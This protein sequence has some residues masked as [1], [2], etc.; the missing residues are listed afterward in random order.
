MPP[1]WAEIPLCLKDKNTY[2]TCSLLNLLEYVKVYFHAHVLR[3]QHVIGHRKSL[4]VKSRQKN[5]SIEIAFSNIHDCLDSGA[6][7]KCMCWHLIQSVRNPQFSRKVEFYQT[8]DKQW[9]IN[10]T[11]GCFY[12]IN[13]EN[14]SHQATYCPHT[15]RKQGNALTLSSLASQTDL[16]INNPRYYISQ[17][18]TLWLVN[19]AG[20][21]PLYSMYDPP[22]FTLFLLSKCFVVYCQVFLTFTARKSL[23]LSF[24]SKICMGYW[25]S[26]RSRWL[27]IGQ[28]LFLRVN[29]PRRSRGP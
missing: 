11:A 19:L 20:R 8:C 6:C 13:P 15:W 29:G 12:S 3:K 18:S 2:F 4:L 28:V 5:H 24:T 27:D 23:K 10:F 17:V 14:K 9:E 22:K 25:P 26:V 1:P 16:P 21:I 7:W